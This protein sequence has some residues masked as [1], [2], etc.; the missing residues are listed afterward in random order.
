LTLKDKAIKGASWSLVGHIIENISSFI[1]GIILAR[2]LTPS[3]YGLVGMAGVFIFVTYV[4]VDSGFSTALI[5]KKEC[6]NID[7]S[8]VF[9]VNLFISLFFFLLLYFSAGFIADFYSEPELVQII[10]A[11]SVLIILYALSIV[12]RSIITRKINL[13]LL[14]LIK[15]TSQISSGVIGIILAYKGYGV[16]SLVWKTLLN[17]LFINLQFWI[18]NKWFPSFEFSLISLRE[19][20]SF[21]SKLLVSGI[22][23]KVYEQLYNLV[24][25]KFFSARELGLY[26]RA[27]QFKSLPSESLSGAIMSVSFP[28]FAQVQDDPVRLKHIAKKIIKA[29]MFVNIPAMLGMAA[30]S[31]YLIV[32]LVGSQWV[33]ST[34]YLQL[35]CLAGLFYPLHPI[36]LNIITALGRS[37]LFLRLEIVKKLLAIPVILIGIM[38]NVKIMIIGMVVTSIIAIFINSYYTKKLIDYGIRE[39]FSD[40]S[41]SMFVGI[42]MSIL[43]FIIGFILR[44]I[45]PKIFLLALQVIS[46]IGITIGIAYATRMH[47]YFEFKEVLVNNLLRKEKKK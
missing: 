31:R 6:T 7:F 43:V 12:H 33:D 25:G 4:F 45:E 8:T 35:L 1:I 11:L 36:N 40:I 22:I 38:T 26:T 44:N 18:F 41:G 14:N 15:I 19:M 29:T 13:K 47:E 28:V 23:N 34:V 46:G 42:L 16:W 32:T 10:R 27:N 20:F 2:L 39:Q 30:I 3:E 21:S 5:Q 17:Q 9:Y 24:I 37:D